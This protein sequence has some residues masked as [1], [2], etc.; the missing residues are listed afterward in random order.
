MSTARV[1][2]SSLARAPGLLLVLTAALF[3]PRQA[4][5]QKMYWA[6]S[7][8]DKIQRA[9][10]DG[11]S[12]E[13]V[14]TAGLTAA[15][16]IAIDRAGGK[17]YWT[18]AGLD[19]ITR[20]NLDG[21]G[22]L[23]L[24]TTGLSNPRGIA[25]DRAGGKMYWA[26]RITL[27]IQRANLD[28]T[29]VEDLVAT[30]VGSDPR[31]IA[32]DSAGGKMYWTDQDLDKI[33]RANLDGTGVEDLVTTGLNNCLDI[34]LDV[35]GGKMYWTDK[36]DNTVERANLDG[37]G[38]EVLVSGLVN[39]WGIGLDVAAGKVYWTDQGAPAKLQR[40]NLDG[41]NVEDLIT[42]SLTTPKGLA[43][44]GGTY[45]MATGTYTG[46][47]T[48]NRGI[49]GVGFH[50]HVV[51]IKPDDSYETHVRTSTMSGDASKQN[52]SAAVLKTNRI[53]SLEADG[54]TLGDADQVNKD[55]VIYQWIAFQ[56]ESGKLH[57][58]SYTGNGNDNRSITGVGF[59]PKYLIVLSEGADNAY[60]RF[61]TMTGDV[62]V[63]F[64]GASTNTNRIQAFQADGFQL[65]TAAEVN[66]NGE[67]Y[68]YIAFNTVTDKVST[69]SYS[70]TGVA[71]SITG[72]GFQPKWV[73]VKAVNNSAGVHRSD[74]LAGDSTQYFK[75]DPDF[76][77]GIKTLQ[78]DGFEVGTHSTVNSG[79]TTYHWASFGDGL[80][81]N[82]RSIGTNTGTIY[83]TGN[84]S[85]ASGATAVTFGGG[86]S[87]P[88]N[89]GP[90]D[91]LTIGSE[92]F[93][94]LTRDTATTATVQI[95]AAGP[96]TNTAYTIVRAYNTL[97][98]W[99]DDRDG[100]LIGEGRSEVGVAYND[101]PF[102]AIVSIQDSTTDAKHYMTLTVAESQRH[103]GTAGTGVVLDMGGA[104]VNVPV[105]IWDP[106][107]KFE[108][109]EVT[110]SNKDG[111]TVKT[112]ATNCELSNLI[113]HDV[114]KWG[115]ASWDSGTTTVR[116]CVVYDT[117]EVGIIIFRG[118]TTVENCTVDGTDSA[119]GIYF[120]NSAPTVVTIRNTISV[121][122]AVDFGAF[123]T[124]V[125]VS[126]FGYNMFT[127]TLNFT[128]SSYDGNNQT[129][130]ADLDDLFIS[131][132]EGSEDYNLQ[133]DGHD[134]WDTGLDLSATFTTDITDT[135]RTLPWE[136][137]AYTITGVINRR[138]IGTNA[139]TLHS[140][141][142]ASITLGTKTV[143]FSSATLPANIG[144][145]DELV[146]GG[147]TFY[148]YSRDS[149]GQVTTQA[150]AAST[151]TSAAYTIKRVYNTLPAW[152][153]AVE[154]D[155]VTD[156]RRE[157]GVAY[158]D[159]PFSTALNID[160]STTDA[161][162]YLMLTV[163]AGQRHDGTAST[164]VVLDGGGFGGAHPLRINDPYTRIE[165]FRITDWS[166]SATYG[167]MS[168]ASCTLSHLII[169]DIQRGVL[170]ATGAATWAIRNT[171]VFDTPD[172]AILLQDGTGTVENCTTYSPSAPYGVYAYKTGSDTVVAV[173]NTI[174][175][176]AV[177]ADFY[178]GNGITW[179]YFGNNMFD[180]VGN[181]ALPQDGG[182][183]T[184]P[185]NLDNLFVSI[186]PGSEDLHLEWAGHDAL[187]A[188]LDL[189]SSFTTDIDGETWIPP[190]DMGADRVTP[191]NHR[192]IGTTTGTIYSAGTA[193]IAAG[194]PF[195][196]F[197]G[198]TLPANVGPGDK[199][200][201][202]AETFHIYRKDSTTQVA[203]HLVA[204]TAHTAEAYTISRAYNTLQ[205]WETAR[206]GDLVTE[207]RREFGVCYNDGPFTG[208]LVISGSTTDKDHFMR[209]TVADGQRH[210][211]L[212][213]TGAS[214]DAAGGFGGSNAID[215]EDQYTRIEGLEIKNINDAG[216]GIYFDDAPAADNGL[217][218]GVFVHSFW[219]FGNAGVDV[220]AQNVTVRNSFFDGTSDV[221]IRLLA[222]STA[223]IENCTLYGDGAAGSGV[224]DAAGATATIRNTISVNH[225][226]GNDFVLN[227]SI[228]FFGNNMFSTVTGF[229][230]DLQNGGNQWPPQN[231][232]HLF[233]SKSTYDL[234]LRTKGN[235]AANAG[236]DLSAVF[237]DDIDGDVR[238]VAWDIGADEGV[239]GTELLNP[240]VLRWKEQGPTIVAGP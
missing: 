4:L 90:G 49:T 21:T 156:E 63:K 130:P 73:V 97:Q 213:N 108:W 93:H 110:N 190:W 57:V 96:H 26:D 69:G 64:G 95:A 150:A 15:S 162:H 127:T 168:W 34:A 22:V 121:G 207:D 114:I 181:F 44:G 194:S 81:T 43:L 161:S 123:T 56:S 92:T 66:T 202:G 113:V 189:S 229:D 54:F 236:L 70:G 165:W 163:A 171:I 225:P 76:S 185:T 145:G 29:S 12:V 88:T 170:I 219:Q 2:T 160:G 230:P 208:R 210:N 60:Q 11:T 47:G 89:V 111:S 182:H 169:H 106:Y 9:N 228:A 5:A 25:I 35:V 234:H 195:V 151:H 67:T 224:T 191:S 75:N 7:T 58:D 105:Q 175:V 232:K 78:P 135:T 37:T 153:T 38:A 104:S 178:L 103:D 102:T 221:G 31:G 40:A 65:G 186:A 19:K 164:G 146:I 59:Q 157:V 199:L 99:E 128:P 192:S 77:N 149:A 86:A 220:G 131:T 33:Q 138:S 85:I 53:Q 140:S 32:V 100:D 218:S 203:V 240:K 188:G 118:T 205:A 1:R 72:A 206:Q 116:N 18:D 147:E 36:G 139:A 223:T 176:G 129:P 141:G 214:I 174:A 8:D 62:S 16:Y 42:T 41:T 184:P 143:T 101:G 74:A 235:Y 94:I 148:I 87:L 155:L 112:A 20:A 159:G 124:G 82:Y 120:L 117:G 183:Q 238:V 126:Y 134:A 122:S 109:F 204:A 61:S 215:V 125:T 84:A 209:V 52:V 55:T 83:S 48:D 80:I 216:N 158:N 27:K 222:G 71:H 39:P 187:L 201:I 133:W 198:A 68:H 211:G 239:P 13:N 177:T 173:K 226:A 10:L 50:P 14:I 217:V 152:E 172:I 115:I 237:T 132:T 3:V 107:T 180:T 136:M 45:Q 193:T 98:A 233:I 46:N 227:A 167:V 79:G 200:V 30:G 196:T 24:I 166:S 23:D 6:D 197:S 154:G 91:K 231:L 144:A 51:F 212:I 137:G 28:G 17:I 179:D 142:N 119:A